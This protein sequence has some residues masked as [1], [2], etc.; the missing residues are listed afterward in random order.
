MPRK[1]DEILKGFIGEVG[2]LIDARLKTFEINLKAHVDQTVKQA[3]ERIRKD[4]AT[5]D[6]I[7]NMA[8]KDDINRL[9]KKIDKFSEVAYQVDELGKRVEDIEE[10]IGVHN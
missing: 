9:E 6:D 10:K 2:T 7:K 8:T 1:S 5:K 4:M 3:E